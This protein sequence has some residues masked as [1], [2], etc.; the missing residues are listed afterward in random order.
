M[1]GMIPFMEKLLRL[2]PR[3][4]PVAP[5]TPPPWGKWPFEFASERD[6]AMWAGSRTYALISSNYNNS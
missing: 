1:G 2:N 4:V 5:W 6:G 3:G